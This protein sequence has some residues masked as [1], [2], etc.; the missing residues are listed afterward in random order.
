MPWGTIYKAIEEMMKILINASKDTGALI[1]YT[2]LEYA[3]NEIFVANWMYLSDIFTT[4]MNNNND[5][6]GVAYNN[7]NMI[8]NKLDLNLPIDMLMASLLCGYK[9]NKNDINMYVN[10]T[11]GDSQ[12]VAF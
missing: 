11:I 12:F 10:G 2:F 3:I 8:P 7:I 6:N 9:L 4:I 1:N 5:I